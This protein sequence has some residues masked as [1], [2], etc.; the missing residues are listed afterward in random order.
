MVDLKFLQTAWGKIYRGII[1]HWL[2]IDPPPHNPITR[3]LAVT[4]FE[5]NLDPV[6]S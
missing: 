2:S 4:G 6:P 3:R 5:I 1:S